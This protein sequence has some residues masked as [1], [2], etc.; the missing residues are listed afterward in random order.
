MLF[1][2]RFTSAFSARSLCA[3]QNAFTIFTLFYLEVTL[4]P[5]SVLSGFEES[6]QLNFAL[7]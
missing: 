1:A 2:A 4:P 6:M 7:K 5:F 3:Q